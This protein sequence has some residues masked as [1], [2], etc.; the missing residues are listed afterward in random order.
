MPRGRCH[1]ALLLALQKKL[2][3]E[4]PAVAE[5]TATYMPDF[6]AGSVA[7]DAM[8]ALG[9]M[10]KWGSHFYVE[11]RPDTWGKAV[12]G[13]FLAHQDLSDVS[14][15]PLPDQVLVMGYLSHLTADEAFRDEVTVHVHGI[16]NW[17]PII[18]GLW[19]LVD[20][21]DISHPN[22]A[23]DIDRFKRKTNIGFISCD[24]VGAFLKKSRGWARYSD[25]LS[26]ERVFLDMIGKPLSDGDIQQRLEANRK[27]AAPFL[28]AD[29]LQAFVDL[30]V[31]RAFDEVR[32]FVSNQ[33]AQKAKP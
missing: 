11:E 12:S 26:H 33:Y 20:E 5:L 1:F 17:R 4:L 6:L 13:M 14:R 25:P 7:P 24:L 32:R 10:G 27:L 8:R 3:A 30:A 9:K 18:H 28:T 22:L 2:A 21:L 15:L 16:E 29:R 19:S 23:R 31:L